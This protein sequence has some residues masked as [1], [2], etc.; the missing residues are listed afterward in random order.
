[1]PPARR[2]PPQ[3]PGPGVAVD[4]GFGVAVDDGFAVAVDA[5]AGGGGSTESRGLVRGGATTTPTTPML[6]TLTKGRTSA[7]RISELPASSTWVIT[8]TGTP[9]TY[10]VPS[11]EPKV[12]S[13]CPGRSWAL[14]LNT[15][16]RSSPALE[17]DLPVPVTAP[18][19]PVPAS[20]T[21]TAAL[22]AVPVPTS[23][24]PFS[25]VSLA[26]MPSRRP[27][28]IVIVSA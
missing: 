15:C 2:G 26:L 18:I 17:M 1:R 3:P 11:A 14:P 21:P 22:A 28:S 8:P 24:A 16:R 25:T 27:A 20:R 5:G 10:G 4:A 23:P 12:T 6:A 9:A 7:W 13:C 19:S